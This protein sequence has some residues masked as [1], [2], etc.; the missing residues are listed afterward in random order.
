MESPDTLWQWLRPVL[1]PDGSRPTYRADHW[2]AA[3]AWLDSHARAHGADPHQTIRWVGRHYR[4]ALVPPENYAETAQWYAAQQSHPLTAWLDQS[5]AQMRADVQANLPGAVAAWSAFE[6]YFPTPDA[7]TP[8]PIPGDWQPAD[9]GA[10]VE[11][12]LTARTDPDEPGL[13]VTRI[14]QDGAAHAAGIRVG[15]RLTHI[16]G[17][18]LDSLA[19]LRA[20]L[21]PRAPNTT[22]RITLSRAGDVIQTEVT[23]KPTGV[24]PI[25]DDPPKAPTPP[26]NNGAP[27]PSLASEIARGVAV[28]AAIFAITRLLGLE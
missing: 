4:A 28:S 1:I 13:I 21:T 9:P 6:P 14:A 10:L 23:L 16:D 7:L 27:A 22:A 17:R 8:A 24:P 26:S 20:D 11:I 15:D 25:P 3:A 2:R 12:G 19:D 18:P 5:L